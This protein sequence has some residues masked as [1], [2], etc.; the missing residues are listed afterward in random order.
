MAVV[1]KG[2]KKKGKKNEKSIK[3]PLGPNGVTDVQVSVKSPKKSDWG[4]LEPLHEILKAIGDIIGPL[5]GG[6][7]LYGLLIGLLIA[8]WFWYSGGNRS[9]SVVRNIKTP[10]DAGDLMGVAFL[11]SPQRIAA[12]E[13]IW[14]REES[15]LWE[16]L[17]DRVGMERLMMT[18]KEA[19]KRDTNRV[20]PRVFDKE[21]SNDITFGG[22][23]ERDIEDAI[24]VT[25]DK[26]NALK[27]A[28]EKRKD[29]KRNTAA[30]TAAGT[31]KT[32]GKKEL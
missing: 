25:E 2:G 31:K 28:V 6:N 9:S 32:G 15:E 27:S 29:E 30:T 22:A 4:M 12:Y 1:V 7:L 17:E 14:R 8:S 3:I 18:T 5:I 21:G 10:R 24:R 16:W 20:D 23:S 19:Q 11:A 13:E 26:L